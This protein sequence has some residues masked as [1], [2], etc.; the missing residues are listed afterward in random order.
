MPAVDWRMVASKAADSLAGWSS[1][2]AL[3]L[4]MITDP[5]L[6]IDPLLH[7]TLACPALCSL[8]C[9]LLYAQS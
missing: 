3:L 5:P 4:Y 6:Y 1:W 9:R 2:L 8:H 7:P